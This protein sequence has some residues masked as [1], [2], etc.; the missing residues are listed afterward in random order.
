MTAPSSFPM[1]APKLLS[2]ATKTP[3]D[4]CLRSSVPAFSSVVLAAS[5][6]NLHPCLAFFVEMPVH[7][8]LPH[9]VLISE[10]HVNVPLYHLENFFSMHHAA[11]FSKVHLTIFEFFC[12]SLLFPLSCWNFLFSLICTQ[13]L[14]IVFLLPCV[15][16]IS[17]PLFCAF[18]DAALTPTELCL[19]I[20]MR[21][22]HLPILTILHPLF[23][24]HS[25]PCF[26]S[27]LSSS[28][29]LKNFVSKS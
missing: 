16:S 2:A 25:L 28:S 24:F 23:L 1:S 17:P 12:I 22:K 13:L 11:Q 20:N 18:S 9:F 19:V 15:P 26:Y 3:P 5:A 8:F 29:L 21:K 6:A 10:E 4:E 27:S 7:L 14:S